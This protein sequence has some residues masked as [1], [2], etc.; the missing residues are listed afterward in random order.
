MKQYVENIKSGFR[1]VKDQNGYQQIF[2]GIEDEWV[3][4]IRNGN[5]NFDWGCLVEV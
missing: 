4:E 2:Y 5:V 1:T 3:V